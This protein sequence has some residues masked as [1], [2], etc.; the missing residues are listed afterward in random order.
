MRVVYRL[1]SLVIAFGAVTAPLTF[2]RESR[3]DAPA[4]GNVSGVVTILVDDAPKADRSGVVVYLENVPGAPAAISQRLRTVT[5]CFRQAL[6][7]RDGVMSLPCRNLCHHT[8]PHI[9]FLS[10]TTIAA[11]GPCSAS[12]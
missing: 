6:R 9:T 10:S 12:S 7:R 3:A 8:P 5:V 11:S 2:P 4:V 1:L